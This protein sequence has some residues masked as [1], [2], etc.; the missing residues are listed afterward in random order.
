MDKKAGVF[1]LSHEDNTENRY[2]LEAR[3]IVMESGEGSVRIL[4]SGS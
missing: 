1:E 4:H 2:F 3:K